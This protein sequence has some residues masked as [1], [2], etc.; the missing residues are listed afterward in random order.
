MKYKSGFLYVTTE[1]LVVPL[2]FVPPR[3][4]YLDDGRICT[5]T[6]HPDGRSRLIVRAPFAWDGASFI[7]FRWFGTPERWKTASAV[8]D[9]LYQPIRTGDLPRSYRDD[10]DQLFY[11]M[12]RERGVN[13]LF[14]LIA[15]YAVRLGGNFAVRRTNPVR[16][17]V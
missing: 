2:P 14:A 1:Y 5:S 6:D 7:L 10:V 13:I 4:L 17:V 15:Y 16:E 8:H 12:L 3:P 9:A 11:S